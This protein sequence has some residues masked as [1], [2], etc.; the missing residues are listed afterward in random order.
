MI[1][2]TSTLQ[3]DSYC[4]IC[5]YNPLTT[6]RVLKSITDCTVVCNVIWV[7]STITLLLGVYTQDKQSKHGYISIAFITVMSLVQTGTI[8]MTQLS[9]LW[10]QSNP[11]N[12]ML[13]AIQLVN[14]IS[15]VRSRTLFM[16]GVNPSLGCCLGSLHQCLENVY[17]P[18]AEFVLF[19]MLPTNL[20]HKWPT[21]KKIPWTRLKSPACQRNCIIY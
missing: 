11:G 21:E 4:N 16:I 7:T 6:M 15:G 20:C 10:H 13:D 14:D 18:I 17:S 5:S 9:E 12:D 3:W 8:I 1:T 19:T 2:S